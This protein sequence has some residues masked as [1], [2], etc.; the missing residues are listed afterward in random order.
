MND[1]TTALRLLVNVGGFALL[2][3]VATILIYLDRDIWAASF[4][5]AALGWTFSALMWTWIG[6][7]DE[8]KRT[9]R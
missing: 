7:R 9:K 1:R 4:G 5:S 8:R 3:T 6:Y 2:F